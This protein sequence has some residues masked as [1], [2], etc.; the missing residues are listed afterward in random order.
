MTFTPPK[1][2]TLCGSSD[3]F[4]FNDGGRWFVGQNHDYEDC[5]GNPGMTTEYLAD[6]HGYAT[7]TEAYAAMD[8]LR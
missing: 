8:G 2:T 5:E 4:V 3:P 1:G 7:A 6:P